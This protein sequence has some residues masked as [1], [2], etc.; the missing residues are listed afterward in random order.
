MSS[1]EPIIPPGDRFLE[2]ALDVARRRRDFESYGSEN[3]ALR[4]LRRRCPNFAP[5]EYED[6]LNRAYRLYDVAEELVASH[7]AALW[8]N[9]EAPDGQVPYATLYDDLV[10]QAR[11]RCPGFHA[12]SYSSTLGWIWFWHHLK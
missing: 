1:P 6:A 9:L 4:A 5:A 7:K 3:K 10:E 11:I 2:V 8:A 12:H